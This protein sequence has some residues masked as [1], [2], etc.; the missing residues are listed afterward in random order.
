[1]QLV[2]R[3]LKTYMRCTDSDGDR[4][5]S[6][7]QAA[8]APMIARLENYIRRPEQQQQHQQQ[9]VGTATVEA[10]KKEKSEEL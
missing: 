1:M 10:E 8:M 4:S 5:V 7:K 6:A 3:V 2:I 9:S